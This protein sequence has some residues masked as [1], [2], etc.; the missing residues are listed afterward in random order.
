M[1]AGPQQLH[2]TVDKHSLFFL[3]SKACTT[4]QPTVWFTL[5]IFLVVFLYILY[6]FIC[7]S[8]L[9]LILSPLS[10]LRSCTRDI[11]AAPNLGSGTSCAEI[12]RSSVDDL[13]LFTVALDA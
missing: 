1:A 12:F 2:P 5:S 3:F 6:T 13:L 11:S 9:T 4:R 7:P 10:S 8:P